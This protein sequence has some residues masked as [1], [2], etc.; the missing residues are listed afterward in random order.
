[1][2][3]FSLK[4]FRHDLNDTAILGVIILKVNQRKTDWDS[5]YQNPFPISTISRAISVKKIKKIINIFGA[6]QINNIAEIGGGNSF[7]V[8]HFLDSQ[9][10]KKY[11]VIDNCES[12][13][14]LFN[15]RFSQDSR[16]SARLYN[17]LKITTSENFDLV[18]SIGLIEHFDKSGTAKAIAS[19]FQLCKPKGIVLITFPTPTLLYKL[20]RRMAEFAGIWRFYD[21]RPLN[22]EEVITECSKFGIRKHNSI[23]WAI[24]LTQGYVVF[25]KK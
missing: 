24:G 17:A 14:N 13:I 20:I 19:H 7:F 4:F 21:E 2:K 16:V 23:L 11:M 3:K 10:V 15:S 18:F 6:N 9:E 8:N 25:E 1:M 12:A 22:F 5:Y